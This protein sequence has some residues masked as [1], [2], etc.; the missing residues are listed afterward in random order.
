MKHACQPF[1][2]DIQFQSTETEFSLA[3]SCLLPHIYNTSIPFILLL[4]LNPYSSMLMHIT[5]V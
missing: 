5:Q 1:N 3:M 4:I 2:H